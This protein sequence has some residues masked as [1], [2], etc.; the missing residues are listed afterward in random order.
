MESQSDVKNI[1]HAYYLSAWKLKIID[2]VL[3]FYSIDK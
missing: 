2:F 1:R 3:A